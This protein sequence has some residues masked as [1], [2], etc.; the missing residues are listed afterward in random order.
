MFH[1]SISGLKRL[2][3]LL[4]AL[5]CPAYTLHAHMEQRA[6]LKHLEGFVASGA[7]GG[8]SSSGG[9]T[10]GISVLLA[11]DVAARGLDLPAVDAVIHFGLP[12][13][14]ETFVHRSGRT[15]RGP[16][17]RGLALSLVG[18]KDNAAYTRLCGALGMG[19][20]LAEFPGEP[21]IARAV[22]ARVR[23]ARALAEALASL[24]QDSAAQGWVV[25]RAE[26]MGVA[27]DE[28]TVREVGGLGEVRL[29]RSAGGGS[30]SSSSSSSG[31]GGGAPEVQGHGAEVGEEELEASRERRQAIAGLRKVLKGLLAAPLIPTG[32]SRRYV[33]GNPLL[34]QAMHP[35]QAT[36][37]LAPAGGGGRGARGAQ[38]QRP[39]GGAR[40]ARGW[41]GGGGAARHFQEAGAPAGPAGKGQA[42]ARASRQDGGAQG[43]ARLWQAG[44]GEEVKGGDYLMVSFLFFTP[45]RRLAIRV[46]VEHCQSSRRSQALT[47]I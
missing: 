11:T 25:S 33:T 27:L 42:C 36:V 47:T 5:R 12:L 38:R 4:N 20:G 31:A 40:A 43:R 30:S 37:Q 1:N 24:A 19:T 26:E 2:A 15:A 46:L 41:R 13:T 34:Q 45:S 23:A 3:L 39:G 22:A 8:S 7:R 17:G 32:T 6:R 28:E 21:G 16:G 9:G 18:P 35:L 44:K 29:S 10:P 14:A